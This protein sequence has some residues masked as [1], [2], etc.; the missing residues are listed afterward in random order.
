M[1]LY[2][3]FSVHF[4]GLFLVPLF[5]TVYF[6]QGL[7]SDSIYYIFLNSFEFF[8][9]CFLCCF[10]YYAYFFSYMHLKN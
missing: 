10:A 8:S 3:K 7:F 9:V 1:K 6:I 2:G 5:L 4:Y